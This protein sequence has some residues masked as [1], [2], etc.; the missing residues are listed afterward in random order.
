MT[1]IKVTIFAFAIFASLIQSASIHL[2]R[3]AD[4]TCTAK[5]SGYLYS[6]YIANL[7]DTSVVAQRG[8]KIGTAEDQTLTHNDVADKFQFDVCQTDGWNSSP[9]EFG[10]LKY[11]PVG[12]Y[13]AIT[14]STVVQGS[15]YPLSVQ[16]A[17]F[18]NDTTLDR[19]WFYA[20]W[21]N[22]KSGGPYVTIQLNGNP[23]DNDDT[24]DLP[25]A[26]YYDNISTASKRDSGHVYT[27][28]DI[29][30]LS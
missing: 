1:M 26:A 2:Q 22:D 12:F 6:T 24:Y 8:F 29:T 20:F 19:Q 18:A 30:I 14:A 25:F 7:T 13:Q 17:A 23:N 10:Q 11:V 27:L 9:R 5:Y 21:K 4:V 28:F 16:D 3:R 15:G